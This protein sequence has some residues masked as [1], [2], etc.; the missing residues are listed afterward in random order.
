MHTLVIVHDLVSGVPDVFLSLWVSLLDGV[1]GESWA[2]GVLADARSPRASF[3]IQA[4]S[5]ALC[6][7]ALPPFLFRSLCLPTR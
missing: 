7:F 2:R 1:E 6:D 5:C 3:A 4:A